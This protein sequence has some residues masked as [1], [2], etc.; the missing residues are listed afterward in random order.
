MNFLTRILT[1]VF[2]VLVSIN[3]ANA[4]TF[5]FVAYA[6]YDADNDGHFEWG[7]SQFSVTEDNITL[8]ATGKYVESGVW[9][10]AYAYLDQGNAG[11]GVCKT[12]NSGNQ[13]TPNSDDNVTPKESLF[14][15]FDQTVELAQVVFRNG[16]HGTSFDGFF[17][18]AVLSDGLW[19]AWETHSLEHIF[20][21]D[22]V[23]DA[24]AFYN[25]NYSTGNQYQFYIDPLTVTVPNV[26]TVPVP[27][28]FWLFGT[29][30]FGMSAMRRKYKLA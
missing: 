26:T 20:N 3:I 18:L 12:I 27:A 11:L 14:L 5:D 9:V 16:G 28:A 17:E 15:H 30:L 19:S 22:I 8:N 4:T 6:D 2:F 7:Y 25:P 24:F 23:G 10:D 29:A 21:A 13:C 1:L